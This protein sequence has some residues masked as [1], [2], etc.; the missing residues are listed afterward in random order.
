MSSLEYENIL[1]Y[2]PTFK[3]VFVVE[4]FHYGMFDIGTLFVGDH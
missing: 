2:T 1:N 3:S 4:S